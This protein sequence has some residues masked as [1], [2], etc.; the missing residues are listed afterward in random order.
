MKIQF[1]KFPLFSPIYIFFFQNKIFKRCTSSVYVKV[2]VKDYNKIL[3]YS[4]TR[5][6]EKNKITLQKKRIT[7]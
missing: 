3:K 5:L 1:A 2:S 6:D 4:I 7:L